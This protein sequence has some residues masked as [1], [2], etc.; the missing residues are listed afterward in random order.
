[1][2]QISEGGDIDWGQVAIDGLQGAAAGAAIGFAGPLALSAVGVEAASVGGVMVTGAVA[3]TASG[4]TELASQG[5]EIA[6]GRREFLDGE[7][8]A[9]VIVVGGVAG[10]IGAQVG[11]SVRSTMSSQ[12]STYSVRQTASQVAA[13]E[14]SR[15]QAPV[16]GAAAGAISSNFFKSLI[17]G[18]SSLILDGN[19]K[20]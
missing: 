10:A 20:Q 17:N 11:S 5:A 6:T 3:G 8:I 12:T 13:A 4:T 18:T 16:I 9:T 2:N 19:E 15:E 14:A 1:M 7:Q